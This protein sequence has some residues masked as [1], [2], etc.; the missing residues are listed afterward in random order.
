MKKLLSI[1]KIPIE[2]IQSILKIDP[3]SPSGLTWIPKEYQEVLNLG[4]LN[5]LIK[6]LA[7][8][9]SLSKNA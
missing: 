6:K 7:I 8:N 5:M 1:K 9:I 3:N 4:T 2:Y